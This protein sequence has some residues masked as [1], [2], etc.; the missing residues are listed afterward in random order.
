MQNR[1]FC[2]RTLHARYTRT[3]T[4]MTFSSRKAFAE[5]YGIPNRYDFLETANKH[6]I[7]S[8]ALDETHVTLHLD[9][10]NKRHNSV[11]N[12]SQ[13]FAYNLLVDAKSNEI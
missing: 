12:Q 3:H 11:F 2:C 8:L 9:T 5:L 13:S 1:Y 10:L 7:E 6:Q 4:R